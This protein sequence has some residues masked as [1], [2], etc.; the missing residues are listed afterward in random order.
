MSNMFAGLFGPTSQDILAEQKDQLNTSLAGMTNP[1]ERLGMLLGTAAV[2]RPK[3]SAAYKQAVANEQGISDNTDPI[4]RAAYLRQAVAEGRIPA[5]KLVDAKRAIDLL[6]PNKTGGMSVKD[7]TSLHS[8]YTSASVA[9]YLKSGDFGDLS[10]L[11]NKKVARAV[12]KDD[13]DWTA[14]EGSLKGLGGEEFFGDLLAQYG[15]RRTTDVGEDN[16]LD[17]AKADVYNLANTL[18]VNSETPMTKSEALKKAKEQIIGNYKSN[19]ADDEFANAVVG[20]NTA[21]SASPASADT[22]NPN[23]VPAPTDNK[24]QGIGDDGPALQGEDITRDTAAVETDL[25]NAK[26][27]LKEATSKG[28]RLELQKKISKL[29]KELKKLNPVKR[30]NMT[31]AKRQSRSSL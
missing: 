21:G 26:E 9:E 28:R 31:T 25:K 4:A 30:K 20:N 24:G 18:A 8:N 12:A 6:D 27:A 22:S 7:L 13:A 2:S 14:Y 15:E 10:R 11:S 16:R 29:N 1:Y 17:A 3:E 23:Q 5:D 19:Q